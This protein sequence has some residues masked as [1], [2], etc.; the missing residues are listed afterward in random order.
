MAK[1]FNKLVAIIICVFVLSVSGIGCASQPSSLAL[2]KQFATVQLG[3]LAITVS[4]DGNL[5]MPQAFD[6]LFGAPGN[7]EDVL[8]EEGD[9]V[10]A[11]QILARL[12]DTTQRLDIMSANNDVQTKLSNL[13]ETVPLLP[14]FPEHN[15]ELEWQYNEKTKTN[16]PVWA[17]KGI[18]D[19]R[20][21]YPF[22]YP[23]AT[24]WVS[25]VWA[26]D[27]VTRAREL[28]QA[29]NYAAAAS[30]L[31]VASSDLES[32]IKIFEDTIN[33][34]KSGLGNTASF[35]PTDLAGITYL[36]ILQG[37][38]FAVSYIVELRKVVDLI[39]QGQADIETVRVLTAE[40]EYDEAGPMFGTLSKRV[41]KIGKAVINNVN[42]IKTHNYATVYGED[43][44]IYFYYAAEE[45]LDAAQKGVEKDGLNSPELRNNLRIAQHYMQ[46]CNSILGSNDYV[47]QHGLSLKAEQQYKLD[48]QN[49]VVALENKKDDLL[50]TVILA[51]FD[52]TVV[53][54]GVKKDDVLSAMD[55]SSKTAVQ[56][57]DTSQI[58]FQGLVDEIDILKIETGQKAMISVDAVP[59]KVFTGTVSFISP[60]GSTDTGN[61]VKFAVTIKLDPTDV[62]LKGGLT[63][64]ADIAVYNAENVLL[65]PL[66]AVTTAP[67]GSFVTVTDEATGQFEKR[68]VTLG[69]QNYQFAEV[70]SGLQEGDKVIIEEKVVGAPVVTTPPQGPP[71]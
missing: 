29:G 34:P 60:Y 14:Q 43:I 48:L 36:S 66:S 3:N 18:K 26:W 8:V 23:N 30:E 21:S 13:Y 17:D 53:S 1:I 64:T 10:K 70:L 4:V 35:V 46:I 33:N 71:R 65:V 41:D 49:A 62:E 11:G 55:Y 52:G 44:S 5:V 28:F 40:G 25:F 19:S 2:E 42:V 37:P 58:K 39:K 47:L 15:Y 12:D 69:R 9:F 68:Q 61:V 63:A 22:Y 67:A 50:K 7:V 16:E 54:V 31:Y 20:T 32:C 45:K 56:L 6:L 27:E 57:V 24:A 38:S 51:P 59:D